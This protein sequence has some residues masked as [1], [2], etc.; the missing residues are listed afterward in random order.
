MYW[1]LCS[2][3][4]RTIV[5]I[6]FD[7]FDFSL[8]PTLI[9][10]FV[11]FMKITNPKATKNI[12]GQTP[13]AHASNPSYL[14]GWDQRIEV[15]GQWGQIVLKTLISKITK[16]KW[17]GSVVQAVEY[18][19]CKCEDL[20]SDSSPAGKEEKRKKR[21]LVSDFKMECLNILSLRQ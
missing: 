19:L 5:F 6:L 9:A 7:S 10:C 11:A 12:F 18:Q 17:T 14:R 13:V 4:I 20:C 1:Q 2:A 21:D 15:W 16:A 8:Y 3:R